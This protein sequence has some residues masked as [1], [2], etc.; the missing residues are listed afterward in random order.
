MTGQPQSVKILRLIAR[1]NTGGPAV[2][3]VLLTQGLNG[4]RFCSRL[5]TG[6][7]SPGEGDMGYYAESRGVV[8]I[9]IPEL[10]RDI[11]PRNDLIALWKL[12]HLFRREN[13]NIIHTHTAKAGGL[14]RLAGILYNLRHLFFGYG[15]RAKLVHSFHGHLF[16]GYFSPW[17]SRLLVLIERIL[18]VMTDRIIAVSDGIKRDLCEVY[19]ICR[20]SK[21]AV[22][23]VG[24]DFEWVNRLAAYRG[25]MRKQFRVPPGRVTV[26]IIGRL[27]DVKNHRL[28]LSAQAGSLRPASR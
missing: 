26:G 19:K 24:V 17:K 25:A 27:T 18:G 10:G 4:G 21:V 15:Q 8:P 20:D 5:V 6:M 11:S 28:F 2:H 13:P 23:P 9:V 12:Y 14:G 7:V 16:H 22:V 3:T 1:L